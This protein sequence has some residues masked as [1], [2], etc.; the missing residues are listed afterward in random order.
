MNQ[1]LVIG[2][3][4]F[5]ILH[6]EDQIVSGAGGAGMYT[7][8]GARRCGIKVSMFSPCPDPI[9][10]SLTAVAQNL[11][12]WLGPKISPEQLPH[13]EISYRDG[14]TA[15]LT[16]FLGAESDLTPA[17]LPEDLADFDLVHICPFDDAVKQLSFINACR[18]RGAKKIS[19]GTGLFIV[20]K[21]AQDVRAVVEASD[22]FFMNE[23]EATAVFGSLDSACTATGETALHHPRRPRGTRCPRK[24]HYHNS[25]HPN[26]RA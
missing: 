24:F 9:P 8:M 3:A 20:E 14:Q 12:D 21:Q 11:T 10:E 23:Q 1:L 17:M 4:S 19:A 16:A 5:D 26:Q 15:Y 6:L 7:A 25:G 18:M 2:G 22:I 13:F